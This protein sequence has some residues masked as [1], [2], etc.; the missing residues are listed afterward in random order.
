MEIHHSQYQLAQHLMM[1]CMLGTDSS[2]F[3]GRLL[4]SA[5]YLYQLGMHLVFSRCHLSNDLADMNIHPS[6]F[7]LSHCLS[8]HRGSNLFIAVTQRRFFMIILHTVLT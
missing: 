8:F 4:C 7:N 6:E 1:M 5:F 2:E 3:E